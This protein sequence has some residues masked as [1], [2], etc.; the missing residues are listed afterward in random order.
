MC[1]ANFEL[2]LLVLTSWTFSLKW[3]LNVPPVGPKYFLGH[4]SH[5]GWH[6]PL[7]LYVSVI[8]IL[9]SDVLLS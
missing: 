9:V 4:S 6:T 3:A 7:L 1:C 8:W 5:F 2:G